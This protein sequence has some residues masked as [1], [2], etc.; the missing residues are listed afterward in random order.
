MRFQFFKMSSILLVALL[1]PWSLPVMGVEVTT[2]YTGNLQFAVQVAKLNASDPSVGK[3]FGGEVAISGN[4][5]VIGAAH[6]A[7]AGPDSGAAYVFVWNGTVWSEQAKLVASDASEGAW[8][9]TDVSIAGDTIV[10]GALRDSNV[11]ENAGA[12]YVFQRSGTVWTEQ[13]KLL[14]NDVPANRQFGKGVSIDGD[15]L[16]VGAWQDD[17]MGAY[18]GAAYVFERSGTEWSQQAK[19]AAS[20]PA[21][22]DFFGFDVALSGDTVVVG[23]IYDDD[24]A[25][26]AGSA[27]VFRHDGANWIQEQ[28]LTASDIGDSFGCAVAIDGDT[29][30]IGS[31]T[32]DVDTISIAGAAYVFTRSE[33]TWSEQQRLT[34]SDA[35]TSHQFGWSA[36]ISGDVALVGAIDNG[37]STYIFTRSGDAWTEQQKLVPGHQVAIAQNVMVV[38]DPGDDEGGEGAGAAYVY[39]IAVPG[40]PNLAINYASGAPG[41]FFTLTGSNLTPNST[42]TIVVNDYTL[43]TVVT[44]LTGGTT[45]ILSTD[46]ADEGHYTVTAMNTHATTHFRL[47]AAEPLRPQGGTGLVLSV[48]PG[49]ASRWVVYLPLVS[50]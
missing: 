45:L 42:A 44:D 34:A 49:I 39:E 30:V 31:Y 15:T 8:F 48:P 38:G 25:S 4:T 18:A 50:R 3:D 32:K 22:S 36:A 19:L 6:D 11:V 12:A 2:V 7:H 24:G 20:D 10:V 47:D 43:G 35:D 37:G 14:A 46:Q 40:Q 9:G 41:S 27:Y 26:G 5:I 17:E 28:K 13:A 33:A 23:A 1:M 16:A 29:I 21:P